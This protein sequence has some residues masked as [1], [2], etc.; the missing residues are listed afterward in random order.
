MKTPLTTPHILSTVQAFKMASTSQLRRLHYGGTPR[1]RE[2]RSYRHLAR[3]VELDK[4]QRKKFVYDGNAESEYVYQMPDETKKINEHD[5]DVLEIYV[6]L[7][8]Y[9]GQDVAYDPEIK[10]QIGRST[11]TP[12]AFLDLGPEWRFYIEMDRA[13]QEQPRLKEKMNRYVNAYNQYW[14]ENKHGVFPLVVWVCHTARRKREIDR[15]INSMQDSHLFT[16]ILFD[17]VAAKLIGATEK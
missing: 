6:R 8:E 7:V 5:I 10:P 9:A 2:V 15:A 13:S 11:L 17:E 3:L 12:D 1:G 14:D 16:C 4:L